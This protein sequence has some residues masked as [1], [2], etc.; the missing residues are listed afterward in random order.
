MRCPACNAE[1]ADTASRCSSCGKPL[2]RKPRRRGPAD[3]S[4]LPLSP[5]AEACNRAALRAY[6][7][8]LFGLIPCLGL[9][10]GPAAVVLGVLARR[11]GLREP[12]FTSDAQARAAY[13]LGGAIA[14]TNWVGLLLMVAGF[15]V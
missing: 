1:N 7:V 9:I 8:C 3:E 5:R 15:R 11:N 10:L 4:E 12:G 2:N 14:V 13:L 6:R